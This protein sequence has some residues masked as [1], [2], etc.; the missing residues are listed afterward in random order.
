MRRHR[1]PMHNYY[2]DQWG[3]VIEDLERMEELD[4]IWNDKIKKLGT[5]DKHLEISAAFDANYC[6]IIR[7]Y[8][9]QL[10]EKAPNVNIYLYDLVINTY[11]SRIKPHSLIELLKNKPLGEKLYFQP[12]YQEPFQNGFDIWLV[13]ETLNIPIGFVGVI[14]FIDIVLEESDYQ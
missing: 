2:L 11:F 12:K 7:K 9:P 3:A 10:K 6:Q 13:G 4:Q 14:R 8:L 5:I 1:K